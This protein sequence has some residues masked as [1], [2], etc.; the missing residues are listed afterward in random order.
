MD[1]TANGFMSTVLDLSTPAL[2]S[3]SGG[4]HRLSVR[5]FIQT[6]GSGN[7]II[8]LVLRL[9]VLLASWNCDY[10]KVMEVIIGFWLVTTLSATATDNSSVGTFH[11]PI[12]KT[13]RGLRKRYDRKTSRSGRKSTKP[14]CSK[15]SWGPPP[16]C[17]LCCRG[18]LQWLQVIR[19][20]SSPV[21]REREKSLWH[22]R[23]TDDPVAVRA[24]LLA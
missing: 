21:K 14:R 23:S 15:R 1:P 6:T 19:R 12:S 16:L 11:V 18:F 13:G 4:R 2:L 5:S 10:A 7:S 17:N 3:N 8:L 22:E 24:H 9:T 20:F